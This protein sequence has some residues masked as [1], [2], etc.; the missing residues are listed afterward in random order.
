L[1]CVEIKP[2]D[3]LKDHAKVYLLFSTF[4]AKG[5]LC[6]SEFC[7]ARANSKMLVDILKMAG[8]LFVMLFSCFQTHVKQKVKA[9]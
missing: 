9:C 8:L 1:N 7:D 6:A 4:D 3:I 5:K 2:S